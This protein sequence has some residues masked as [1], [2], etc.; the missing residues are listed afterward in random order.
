MTVSQ[1]A[2]TTLALAITFTV[3][4]VILSVLRLYSR[5][6]IVRAVRTDDI[7]LGLSILSSIALTALIIF[8]MLEKASG[9]WKDCDH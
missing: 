9:L 4:A 8:R 5:A 1:P 2:G 7:L 6:V 3:I